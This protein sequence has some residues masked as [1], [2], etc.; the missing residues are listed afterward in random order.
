MTGPF[1]VDALVAG[2]YGKNMKTITER[3]N[4]EKEPEGGTVEVTWEI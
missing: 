1:N 4:R 2:V 3:R